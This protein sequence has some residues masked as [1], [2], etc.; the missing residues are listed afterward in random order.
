MGDFRN[1]WGAACQ[2]VG[3]P[4]KLFTIYGR[5]PGPATTESRI[6]VFEVDLI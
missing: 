4:G 1:A 6:V 2:A 5:L 3:V